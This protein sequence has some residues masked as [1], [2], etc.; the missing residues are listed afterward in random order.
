MNNKV[1]SF[2]RLLFILVVLLV[3]AFSNK[4]YAIGTL[5]VVEQTEEY[6]EYTELSDE[7]KKNVLPP[8]QYNIIAPQSTSTY[9]NRMNNLFKLTDILEDSLDKE[10]DLEI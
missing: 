5:T 1:E 7:E 6:K 2:R 4:V 10:Y 8:K 9:L 3:L